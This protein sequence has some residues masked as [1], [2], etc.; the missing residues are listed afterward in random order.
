MFWACCDGV[1]S[2]AASMIYTTDDGAEN[3]QSTTRVPRA[4]AK[5]PSTIPSLGAWG[6]QDRHESRLGSGKSQHSTFAAGLFATFEDSKSE[7]GGGRAAS[8]ADTRTTASES[9]PL[10]Q[11]ERC[12]PRPVEVATADGQVIKWVGNP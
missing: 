6:A 4:G 3:R 1:P 2:T 12:F 11:R 10:R 8:I 5:A 7:K 9:R